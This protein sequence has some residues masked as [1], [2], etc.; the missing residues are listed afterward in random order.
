MS[1]QKNQYLLYGIKLNYNEYSTD[2]YYDIFEKYMDSAFDS[3]KN[4]NGLLCLFDGMCGDYIY[5][6]RCL[7]KSQ[8][9]ESLD[10]I[11]LPKLEH[12]FMQEIK[13]RL[14]SE[15]GFVDDLGLHLV[16]HSR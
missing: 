12:I 9:Y 4:K 1:V 5:I 8:N 10:N 6:G 16:T 2:Q 15:F 13:D 3:K 7:E 14:K 11:E